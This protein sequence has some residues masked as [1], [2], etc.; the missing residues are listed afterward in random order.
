MGKITVD[1]MTRPSSNNSITR[2]P[3]DDTKLF[4]GIDFGTSVVKGSVIDNGG[5]PIVSDSFFRKDF[6][7][8]S[9]RY[10]LDPDQI[11]WEE[12]SNLTRSLISR[13][14]A[15]SENIR[16]MCITGMV[17]NIVLVD[18]KGSPLRKALLYFDGRARDIEEKLDKITGTP[19]PLNQVLSQLIWLKDDMGDQWNSV[20]K[21]LS[22]HNYIAYRLTG[23]F[24]TDTVTAL[25]CGN[26]VENER[27][28]WNRKLL[29]SHGLDVE[30]LPDILP[31]TSVLGYISGK[32]ADE[33]GL[34]ENVQVVAG[35]TDIVATFIG[36][37]AHKKS[38]MMVSYGTYGCAPMLKYD[39]EK[40]L[41]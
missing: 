23:K 36:F 26:M 22:T 5:K 9:T 12:F 25:E 16:S 27:M 4:L 28:E 34:T 38:D 41:K 11:W 31:P 7:F 30:K 14:G 40:I 33:L 29:S 19:K 15:R 2:E 17:P 13:L 39:I 10:E 24:Y 35:T 21:I 20:Y 6:S 37:G 1:D 32:Y 18:S 3:L 8:D